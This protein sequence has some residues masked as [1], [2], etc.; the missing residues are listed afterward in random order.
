MNGG[1]EASGRWVWVPATARC[2]V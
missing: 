1:E 2:P